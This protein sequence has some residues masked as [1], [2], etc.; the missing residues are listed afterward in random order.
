MIQAVPKSVASKLRE[1]RV[2]EHAILR[3]A[4]PVVQLLGCCAAA[5][6]L[7]HGLTGCGV[8]RDMSYKPRF[9]SE[10]NSG[11]LGLPLKATEPMLPEWMPALTVGAR[12]RL[13]MRCR[14]LEW[15]M[16]TRGSRRWV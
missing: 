2:G 1:G 14:W 3:S 8:G 15:S 5:V 6:V 4:R 9:T 12:R 7:L 11:H 10:T 16:A 13:R